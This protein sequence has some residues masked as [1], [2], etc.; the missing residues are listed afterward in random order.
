MLHKGNTLSIHRL[1]KGASAPREHLHLIPG[2]C[3]NITGPD[4]R[5]VHEVL[6]MHPVQ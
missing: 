2:L 1:V 3:I 6:L 5:H 4:Q